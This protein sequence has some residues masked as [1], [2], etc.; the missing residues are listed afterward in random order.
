MK[1]EEKVRF[2]GVKK[3]GRKKRSLHREKRKGVTPICHFFFILYS[4]L[5]INH[6]FFIPLLFSSSFPHPR[7]NL[8][9]Q[10]TLLATLRPR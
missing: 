7:P 8:D 10:Q 6:L 2:R 9:Q 1:E 5:H 4:F 3:Q